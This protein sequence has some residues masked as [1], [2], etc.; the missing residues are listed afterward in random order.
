M[1]TRSFDELSARLVFVLASSFRNIKPLKWDSVGDNRF[2]LSVDAGDSSELVVIGHRGSALIRLDGRPHFE[3][4]R[5]HKAI[6][7]PP[8]SHTV[9][10][11]FTPYAD[12]GEIVGVDPG[13]PFLVTR[14]Y[15]AL[16]F[17]AYAS[18]ALELARTINDDAVKDALLRALT[19]AFKRV[20]FT[21]VSREQLLLT[22]ELYGMPWGERIMQ[23]ITDD[24][25]NVYVESS[26][27]NFDEALGVLRGLLGGFGKVGVV[28]GVG[29]AHIDAAWLWP[30]EESRRKVLRTFATV[31]TLMKRFNFTY[32]QSSA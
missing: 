7:I 17:W 31:V 25:S 13:K 29:H 30:F 28:F 11:E 12:F 14:D 2:R 24:L 23:T 10:A 4:D 20:P 16:R 18:S 5:Y 27:G 15:S 3:L 22:A 32:V 6:P 19:E 9:E 26:G 1:V 21:S 8:G